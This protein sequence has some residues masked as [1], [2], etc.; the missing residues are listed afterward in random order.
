MKPVMFAA[1]FLHGCG[2]AEVTKPTD[3]SRPTLK[4]E[5]SKP[6][7][8]VGKWKATGYEGNSKTAYQSDVVVSKDKNGRY[9]VTWSG[10]REIVG[11]ALIDGD[12]FAVGWSF[13]TAFSHH[14]GVSLYK[15]EGKK[16]VGRWHTVPGP[17]G[18]EVLERV[19]VK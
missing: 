13:V 8:W 19:E 10:D 17:S 2:T 18:T 16:L 14:R 6:D 7:P 12:T 3:P 4:V 15:L 11:A 1:L 5:E 9:S